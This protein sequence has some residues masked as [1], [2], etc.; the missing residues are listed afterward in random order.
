MPEQRGAAVETTATLRGSSLLLA[1]RLLA[2]AV[3]FLTQVLLVRHLSTAD[4]GAF[5]YGLGVV[6]SARILVSLGHN[7]IITRFIAI[8]RERG[9][10]GRLLGVLVMELLLI[11]SLG[12]ALFLGVVAAQD[13]LAGTV[14]DDRRTIA[15]LAILILLAPLEALDELAE[16]L[17]AAY[18]RAGAILWRQHVLAPAL[19]LGVVVTLIALD[20]GVM[21]L[22]TGYVVATFAGLLLYVLVLRRLLHAE[23]VLGSERVRPT[24]PVREVFGYSLPLLTAEFVYISVNTVSVVVLGYFHGP[25]AV[26]RLR[27]VGPLAE[28]NL[29]VRRQFLRLYLAQAARLY[30]RGD[31]ASL[32]ATYVRTT[33]WLAVLT[34]P[35]LAVTVPF[36]EPVTVTLFGERYASSAPYLALLSLGFYV[37]AAA[38]F[39]AE[40]LQAAGRVRR[41]V[42]AN[43]V[44]IVVHVTLVLVLAYRLGALGVAVATTVALV[45]QN[46]INQTGVRAVLG[47]A[48]PRPLARVYLAVV[49]ATG[50]LG[51]VQMLA[52]LPLIG[53]LVLTVLATAVVLRAT[54]DVL[55]LGETFPVLS[56]LPVVG[57]LVAGETGA[58]GSRS[59]TV[60]AG[61]RR[62]RPAHRRR[63]ARRR[64]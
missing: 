10:S 17:L 7:R 61:R 5:A 36:A 59:R 57:Y 26:G 6:V 9:D 49:L 37:N 23:Q 1:G 25:G 13:V 46:A 21:F 50:L 45:V 12:T 51:A 16:S 30:E 11:G 58:D 42:V 33:A 20:A 14:I 47:A 31:L 2:T 8:Y 19:R 62:H 55:R 64:R 18:G 39:N 44:T 53:G 35:V 4:F 27:A 40:L 60:S 41:L 54:R 34:F 32:R 38:G 52:G 56:R 3:A 43:V 28:L 29:L 15:V 24:A 22:A 63:T 48:V